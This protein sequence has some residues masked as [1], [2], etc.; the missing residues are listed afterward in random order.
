MF[1]RDS[2]C[3]DSSCQTVVIEGC[4]AT[5]FYTIDSS[6][7]PWKYNFFSYGTS[8]DS[9]KYFWTFGSS[10]T[11]SQINPMHQFTGPGTYNVCLTVVSMKDTTCFSQ[12]C[13]TIVVPGS[14]QPCSATIALTI[15]STTHYTTH[16][17]RYNFN[18]SFSTGSNKLYLWTFGDSTSSTSANPGHFY[19]KPGT[20]NVCLRVTNA[21]DSTCTDIKCT[22]IVV[23]PL[24]CTADFYIIRDTTKTPFSYFF[25]DW[26]RGFDLEYFW[27]FGNGTSTTQSPTNTFPVPGTYNVCLTARNKFDTT[28]TATKCTTIVVPSQPCAIAD[29]RYSFDA[30]ATP[31]RYTFYGGY[32]SSNS[33][34][35]QY[36]W[37]FGDG[38]TS[39]TSQPT[40]Q[41]P[42]PGT[43]NVCLTVR[44]T[45]DTSCHQTKCMTFTVGGASGPYPCNIS[46]SYSSPIIS[47][48]SITFNAAS[49][50]GRNLKY[51]WTFGDGGTSNQMNPFHQYANPGVYRVCLKIVS[52]NDTT[53]SDTRCINLTV[54]GPPCTATFEWQTDSL[55]SGWTSFTNLT[56]GNNMQYLWTFGDGDSS[57]STSPHHNYSAPGI[58]L[59]CLK[60]WSN[61]D[62]SCQS[63]TCKVITIPAR[64]CNATFG[65]YYDTIQS[66]KS[67]Y[68]Y[69]HYATGGTS[70]LWNF[71]DGDTSTAQYPN[72]QYTSAGWYHV[73]LTI[74]NPAD[75]CSQTFCDSVYVPSSLGIA[76][77][78]G[79]LSGLSVYP[80]PFE[81]VLNFSISSLADAKA[82]VILVDAMGRTVYR[83]SVMLHSGSTRHMIQPGDIAKGMYLLR[84]RVNESMMIQKVIK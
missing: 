57:T 40:H 15:D 25:G 27:D 65:Y 39:L 11:S 58:Y 45:L 30:S 38:D 60:A 75:S 69:A 8:G 59:V 56:S 79:F 47:P 32:S 84:V 24:A 28:C 48:Q 26:S 61:T 7:T 63:T 54:K 20:Y 76:G 80:V 42:G 71:G 34:P 46:L 36:E 82:D 21:L 3:F 53:C 43:Y 37:D 50:S 78:E 17:N 22:T 73:C 70:F 49:S 14:Q 1:G 64:P 51:Y 81:E 29:F 12:A 62:T 41:F 68:Y 33:G 77:T 23:P 16:T 72:H 9:L 66:Y 83:Q 10:G 13:S 67:V 35:L 19:S 74:K 6:V 18:G 31:P 2:V 55:G 44:S 4:Y 5:F 52:A